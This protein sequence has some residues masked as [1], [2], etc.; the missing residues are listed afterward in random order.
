MG[1]R[2]A[3]LDK[4]FDDL[5][6]VDDVS[7]EVQTGELVALLGP[8]GGRK[9]T[10]LRIIAGLD[11]ADSGEVWLDGTRVDHAH[12][13]ERRVGFVFQH[14][15][16]FRH[17]SVRENIAFGLT[18]QKVAPKERDARVDQLIDLIGLHGFADRMPSQLSGGQRQRVALARA[19]APRPKLLLLDE[20]FGAVDAKVRADL[21]R[22]LRELHDEV[23]VTS[24]FVTHDQDEA[25]AVSDR[26]LIIQKG[27]LEQAGTPVDI[28]DHPQTEF[29]SRFIGDA[30]VLDVVMR[31]GKAHVGALSATV[32]IG[33]SST[34][35]VS[36]PEDGTMRST[37][38]SGNVCF[39][40]SAS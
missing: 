2:V 4:S 18:V 31:E 13:R 7:F 36:T 23:H 12:A 25:F 5:K 33:P 24:I 34:M 35:S 15:A 27:R 3:H 20:P 14:Y 16:L 38:P 28:L 26:V 32:A 22:W 21:R 9:S 30:N 11:S 29:V 10:I 1:I 37:F 39:C 17:M 40:S 19:L 8:S 6:V